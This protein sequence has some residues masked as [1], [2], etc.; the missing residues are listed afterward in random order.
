METIF[1]KLH[2]YT[3]FF[4]FSGIWLH[5]I[6]FCLMF[7]LGAIV[8]KY[9]AKEIFCSHSEWWMFET[10]AINANLW[11]FNFGWPKHWDS[12]LWI[13]FR[14]I[15]GEELSTKVENYVQ[16]SQITF[17]RMRTVCFSIGIGYRI[18]HIRHTFWH[19]LMI[20]WTISNTC[21]LLQWRINSAYNVIPVCWHFHKPQA[22]API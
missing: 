21:E 2:S 14:S 13:P 16:Y 4:C 19:I 7:R 17:S 15:S 22:C 6:Q 20:L 5:V 12:S 11:N 18:T 9:R 10:R 1:F 8:Y 3:T